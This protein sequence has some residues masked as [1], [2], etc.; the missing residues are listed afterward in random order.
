MMLIQI[1]AFRFP[2]ICKA[3][4]SCQ[5]VS[6]DHPHFALAAH[7]VAQLKSRKVVAL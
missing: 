6:N 3:R 2:T 5:A 4:L 1:A 7:T